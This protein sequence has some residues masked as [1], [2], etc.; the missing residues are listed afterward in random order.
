MRNAMLVADTAVF[1]GGHHTAIWKVFAHRGMGFYAGSFGGGD[2]EP[3]ASFATPPAGVQTGTL[4]GTVTDAGS[5]DPLGGVT[6]RLAFQ[7]SGAANPTAVTDSEGHYTITGVPQGHYGKLEI[8]GHGDR[9]D[10]AV[11]VGAGT[12]TV[13]VELDS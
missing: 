1:G 5:G 2:Q 9:V 8:R 13:D 3:A 11:T 7:G 4:E 12:T 6:V 10:R